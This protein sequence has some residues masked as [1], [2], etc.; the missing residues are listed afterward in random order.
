MIIEIEALVKAAKEIN[1]EL[2]LHPEINTKTTYNEL[3]EQLQD[4][5]KEII[6]SDHLTKR[7]MKILQALNATTYKPV[8]MIGAPV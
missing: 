1:E 4:A 2:G 3:V 8:Y 7:T 6:A 5:S